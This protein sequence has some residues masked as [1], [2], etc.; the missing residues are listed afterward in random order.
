MQPVKRLERHSIS[1]RA[2]HKGKSRSNERREVQTGGTKG[3][4]LAHEMAAEQISCSI[5]ARSRGWKMTPVSAA[6]SKA[7]RAQEL[8]VGENRPAGDHRGL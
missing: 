8:I 6:F 3:G 7:R 2:A 4:R 1:R 5:I